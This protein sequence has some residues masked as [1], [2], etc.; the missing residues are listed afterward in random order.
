MPK[1]RFRCLDRLVRG[2][3]AFCFAAAALAHASEEPGT[4]RLTGQFVDGV[5]EFADT[6]EARAAILDRLRARAVQA[7]APDASSGDFPPEHLDFFETRVRPVLAEHCYGCHGPEL[8]RADLRL[9]ARAAMLAGSDSGPIL[10]PGDPDSSRILDA[11]S[12]EGAIKMPPDGKLPDDAIEAIRHWIKLGAPWPAEAPPAMATFDARLEHAREHHWAFRPVG[13]PAPPAV[14]APDWARSPIDAFIFDALA[15][16][17]LEPS[18]DADKR[19]LLRRVSYDLTGLPPTPERMAAFLAD[20][21]PDAYERVVE[22]L[23]DSPHYGERWARHWLDVA[24]YA[25]TKGYVFQEERSFAFSHTYRDYV[26]RAFN[27][28]LPYDEFIQHQLAADLL[29]LGE[30]RAPLAALGFLTLGRR[31]INNIHDITDDRIDVVTRGLLGLTVSCAR[32]HDHKYDPVSIQDYY[33]LYGVFRSA[34]EPAELPLLN[35]PD[36]EDPRYQDYLEEV[37][38]AEAETEKVIDEIQRGL[39]RHARE[40]VAGYLLTAQETL[41]LPSDAEAFR[42]RAAERELNWQIADRWRAYLESDDRAGDPVFRLWR[43]LA[44]LPPESFAGQAPDAIQAAKAEGPVHPRIEA[45][46]DGA[47]PESLAEA[48]ERHAAAFREADDAWKELLAALSQQGAESLPDALPDPALET[49]RQVLYA[50]ESPANIPRGSVF[51]FSDVPTQGRIRERRLAVA[52]IKATHPGRPDRAVALEEGPLF[53]PFVFRRGQPG[54]RGDDVPRRNIVLLETDPEPYAESSG[55]LEF[56]RAIAD[57]ENPLTA[58]VLVNRVWM[59]YFGEPLV[60]TPSDFGLRSDPPTHPELLDYLARRFMDDGWSMKNLHRLIVLSSAYRQSSAARPEALAADPEN[61]LLWRQDRRRLDFEALRDTILAVSGRLDDTLLGESVDITQ[62]PFPVRRTVYSYIE[63][64]NLPGLFRT[65]DFASPDAHTPRRYQTTVPQQ[66]LFMMNSPFIIE[67]ARA[68]VHQDRIAA[69]ETDEDRIRALYAV[70]FQR[71]PSGGELAMGIAFVREGHAEA[72]DA[73][74]WRYGYGAIDA[75]EGAVT[76]FKPFPYFGNG[77]WR[78]GAE[79]PDPELGWLTLSATGGHP[80]DGAG[81]AVIRRWVAPLDGVIVIDGRLRHGND[82][83]DGVIGYIV[84]SREGLLAERAVF[85]DTAAMRVR[86][87]EVR[88]G[89][90]IDFVVASGPTH[91]YDSF[92]WIPRIRLLEGPLTPARDGSAIAARWEADADFAGPPPAPLEPWEQYAQVLLMTNE[93]AF[94]D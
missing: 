38:R 55:R 10:V 65:F 15:R 14:S 16:A 57:P 32:C 33:A 2:A 52:R 87:A 54:L 56:A 21:A 62:E 39:L 46:F 85:N 9:D 17:G 35:E 59:H 78:G 40:N 81:R 93:L 1:W 37:A 91:S 29:E 7:S 42:G 76:N 12:H 44:A 58:R 60:A 86:A 11:L 19:T 80:G 66:A 3:G 77:N 31:F 13:E 94:I 43:A 20:E 48:A 82:K 69:H 5:W 8:Q 22:E 68:L 34:R 72:P 30:D 28:D 51:G 27:E 41:G 63:R 50:P 90:A 49:L 64:Q 71:P 47:P 23:L 53:D 18:P 83:G 88:E 75:D 45:A 25:D 26:I 4:D 36:P 61:R 84:S 89:D 70:C 24:R 92:E 67:Q 79:H 6:P 73:S 74:E